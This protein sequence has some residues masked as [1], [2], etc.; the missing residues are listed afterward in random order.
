MTRVPV[1]VNGSLRQ[2]AGGLPEGRDFLVVA[3]ENPPALPEFE[4]QLRIIGITS[5]WQQ[6]PGLYVGLVALRPAS[7]DRVA[8]LLRRNATGRVGIS[9][10]Y[11][12][13]DRLELALR[14]ART[15]L[16]ASTTADP[17]TV[18]DRAP[19]TMAVIADAEVAQRVV[20]VVL[21]GLEDLSADDRDV[22]LDTL[23]AWSTHDGS[24]SKT[25]IH[26]YC[27]P[28]TVRYRLRRLEERTGRSLTN[29]R[30]VAELVLALE[31]FRAA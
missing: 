11:D 13:A 18:F 5:A 23:A 2:L 21:G 15:A 7:F 6:L 17:V 29:P 14:L 9:P 28:N 25:A 22:L 19:L 3:A 8:D 27:H 26:L 16:A 31:A 1:S 4:E 12:D 20:Q 30:A 24:A 10:M